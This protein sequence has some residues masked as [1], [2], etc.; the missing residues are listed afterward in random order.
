MSFVRSLGLAALACLAL[1]ACG[2]APERVVLVSIDTLRADHVGAYGATG[3]PTP[4]LD[5]VAAE[6]VRFETAIAPTKS[7]P[8]ICTAHGSFTAPSFLART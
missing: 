1:G 3:N 8:G 4:I 2:G 6:G 7:P 5:H